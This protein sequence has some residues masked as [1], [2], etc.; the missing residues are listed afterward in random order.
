MKA[1]RTRAARR[2]HLSSRSSSSPNLALAPLAVAAE[3][4]PR[5]LPGPDGVRARVLV[6]DDEEANLEIFRRMFRREFDCHLAS[7]ARGALALLEGG[8][9]DCAFI[10]YRMPTMDGLQLAGVMA[11]RWP[12]VVRMIVTGNAEV[13]ELREALEGG[14]VAVLLG[15]PWT[16]EQI[17]DGY[18]RVVPPPSRPL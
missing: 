2:C 9:F 10:D 13:R 18:R 5:P 17:L 7:S 6:I 11:E 15:K 1:A 14:L 3:G 16:R 4:V 8:G 12:T